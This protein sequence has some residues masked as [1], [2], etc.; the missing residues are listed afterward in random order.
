MNSVL[1]TASLHKELANTDESFDDRYYVP[2]AGK[3]V[4]KTSC[5]STNL[6]YVKDSGYVRI[7][8][9]SKDGLFGYYQI[10]DGYLIIK[11]VDL[12]SDNESID[13]CTSVKCVIE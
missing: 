10:K 3:S 9:N 2:Y 11:L 8:L 6:V 13:S 12:D 1:T 4:V 7:L 5:D